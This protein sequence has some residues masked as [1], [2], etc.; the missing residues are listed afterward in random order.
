MI[1]IASNATGNKARKAMLNQMPSRAMV[2]LHTAS[3]VAGTP[4]S[5]AGRVQ[6]LKSGSRMFDT[7]RIQVSR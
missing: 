4:I 7:S 1:R 5:I 3:G 2:P 6:P